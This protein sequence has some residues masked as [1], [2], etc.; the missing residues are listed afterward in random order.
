MSD[1][2]RTYI[3]FDAPS[4]PKARPKLGF[5]DISGFEP[6]VKKQ[7]T[8]NDKKINEWEELESISYFK[9][10]DLISEGP[11]EG[12]CDPAG[13]LVS[14]SGI[15]KG[16]YLDNTP[17]INENDTINYRDVSTVLMHGATGQDAI[18]TGQTGAFQ[19]MEDFSY[20]SQ[21]KSKGVVLPS[22]SSFGGEPTASFDGHHTIQDSD[23]DWVALTFNI[24]RLNAIDLN[25]DDGEI[26]PNSLKLRIEGDYTGV[27]HHTMVDDTNLGDWE[28][29]VDGKLLDPVAGTCTTDLT[30]NGIATSPYQEDILFKLVDGRDEDGKR[31]TNRRISVRN[32]T[33]LPENFS[34]VHSVKLESVTEIIKSNMSYPGSA[35]VGSVI[36]AN[37]LPRAPERTFHLKLKKVKVPS[38]YVENDDASQSRHPGTWDG[39]FKDELEWTDN[40]AWIF[41]DIA[42]NERYGLGEYVKEE[43][44]DKWQLFKIAKYC[45]EPVPTSRGNTSYK[46]GDPENEKYV[47]ERRFSCN[48]FLN[49]KME[50]Y[51]ALSEI[52]SVFKGMAFYNGSEVYVSQDSLSEPV[53]N[54]TNSNVLEGNFTYHGSSKN[55]RFTAVKVAYKD[56][57]DNFLPKYEYIEDPEGIIRH[58][59]IEKESAALGCTSRDQ[60]LRLGRW[61]LLT[62]NNEQEVVRFSTDKQGGYLRPGDVIGISDDNRTNFK[63]G[64]RVAKVVGD[65]ATSVDENHILLDQTLDIDEANFKYLKI[66]FIIPN[67]G[68]L[69]EDDEEG[70]GAEKQ[71]KTF[72]HRKGHH[73]GVIDDGYRSA[74]IPLNSQTSDNSHAGVDLH[75][76]FENTNEGTKIKTT[77]FLDML[78]ES[79][80]KN[81]EFMQGGELHPGTLND[82]FLESGVF[83]ANAGFVQH[84][85]RA[86]NNQ[87]KITEGAV[88]IVEASGD[89]R[90]QTK[91][92]RVLAVAEEDDATFT[93]AAL[94]YNRDKFKDVDS[95]STIY[96]SSTQLISVTPSHG[97]TQPNDRQGVPPPTPESEIFTPTIIGGIPDNNVSL[98]INRTGDLDQNDGTF[99]PKIEL[100]FFNDYGNEGQNVTHFDYKIQEISNVYYEK[101]KDAGSV[102]QATGLYHSLKDGSYV[103]SDK[104]GDFGEIS[105]LTGSK[106]SEFYDPTIPNFRSDFTDKVISEVG[107][108]IEKIEFSGIEKCAES[109]ST[110]SLHLYSGVKTEVGALKEETWH[111]IRWKASRK[112]TISDAS[113]EEKV[114]F[115][116]SSADITPPGEPKGFEGQLFF[117]NLYEFN[118][119]NDSAADL[120]LVRLYTGINGPALGDTPIHELQA[121][122]S[123]DQWHTFNI[124]NYPDLADSLNQ[125]FYLTSVDVAGNESL[126]N[127]DPDKRW[128]KT[129]V[130]R[131]G[132]D[133]GQLPEIV[134]TTQYDNADRQSYINIDIDPGDLNDVED[135]PNFEKYTIT[136]YE[137]GTEN[138]LNTYDITEEIVSSPEVTYN[139]R[140]GKAY[141]AKF[142][143][144]TKGGDYVFKEFDG[145]TRVGIIA[146]SDSLDPDK[147][148]NFT[149]ELRFGDTV[150]LEWNYSLNSNDI[151]HGV[152]YSGNSSFGDP[153][154]VDWEE[155]RTVDYPTAYVTQFLTPEEV[156]Y[157]EG[158]PNETLRYAIDLYDFDGNTSGPIESA[159]PIIFSDYPTSSDGFT[160]NPIQLV[161]DKWFLKAHADSIAQSVVDSS[162]FLGFQAW[163]YDKTN[164]GF[165]GIVDLDSSHEGEYP[166]IPGKQLEFL[167]IV[168]RKS[169]DIRWL[170]KTDSAVFVDTEPPTTLGDF[171]GEIWF[172]ELYRFKWNKPPEGD[173]EKIQ[174][175]T[176]ASHGNGVDPIPENL[177]IERF[178]PTSQEILF[179]T[180]EYKDLAVSESFYATAVDFSNN[181]GDI[182]SKV[183]V[184]RLGLDSSPFGD[185]KLRVG[186]FLR[187][188]ESFITGNIEPFPSA[189]ELDDNFKEYRIRLFDDSL[190]PL[191]TVY[192]T[193]ANDL[194][195]PDIEFKVT[196]GK[197][198]TVELCV[199]TEGGKYL[200]DSDLKEDIISA[201]DDTPPGS[202]GNFGGS[203]IDNKWYQ[204]NWDEPTD[205]DIEKIQLYTGV[206]VA[207]AKVFY[208]KPEPTS[209]EIVFHKNN[210]IANDLTTDS[211]FYIAA[212]DFSNNV[213][214][215][216]PAAGIQVG[217]LQGLGATDFQVGSEYNTAE[218]RP[219]ITGNIIDNSALENDDRFLQF[220]IK[221]IDK[222]NNKLLDTKLFKDG[223]AAPDL[224]YPAIAGKE[225]EL[226]LDGQTRD[227][228]YI[229]GI[230]KTITALGDLNP[231]AQI[232]NFSVT[233]PFDDLVF[234]WNPPAEPDCEQVVI[235]SGDSNPPT[236]EYKTVNKYAFFDAPIQ[237]FVEAGQAIHFGAKA[238]DLSDNESPMSNIKSFDLKANT[239]AD[240][241]FSNESIVELED[242]TNGIRKYYRTGD[243]D[244]SSKD[245]DFFETFILKIGPKDKYSVQWDEVEAP[246]GNFKYEVIP[247]VD[248]YYQ[249]WSQAKDKT[250]LSKLTYPIKEFSVSADDAGPNQVDS[251][252]LSVYGDGVFVSWKDNSARPIDFSHYN[253]YTGVGTS[254]TGPLDNLHS[255]TIHTSEY[256]YLKSSDLNNDKFA[257]EIEAKDISNNDEGR[258][259]KEVTLQNHYAAVSNLTV[260]SGILLDD[261]DGTYNSFASFIGTIPDKDDAESMVTELWR[262]NTAGNLAGSQVTEVDQTLNKSPGIFNN[263]VVGEH[264]SIR[265]KVKY[266]NGTTS[267]TWK[268]SAPSSFIA[269][270][271]VQSL[272]G[273]N[274]TNNFTAIS[275]PKQVHLSWD[276]DYTSRP[277]DLKYVNIK[278][279][280]GTSITY[281]IAPG[282]FFIDSDIEPGTV[283][284]Y[285]LELEDRSG[286]K[287]TNNKT[288]T[289]TGGQISNDYLHSLAANKIT[290]GKI[291]AG[292][293]EIS[294]D[295]AIKSSNVVNEGQGAGFFLSGTH[296][297]VGDP[298]TGG[299]GLFFTEDDDGDGTPDILEIRGNF[300]AGEVE[301]GQSSETSLKINQDGE[302]YIGDIN[303]IRIVDGTSTNIASGFF[304]HDLNAE[305]SS[306]QYK[307]KIQDHFGSN[308]QLNYL[309]DHKF[310][311]I[312]YREEGGRKYRDSIPISGH[313]VKDEVILSKAIN[314]NVND[315]NIPLNLHSY[316]IIG[317]KFLV[318]NSGTLYARDAVVAG[319]VTAN[320]F[321]A[322]EKMS[323]GTNDGNAAGTLIQSYGYTDSS[324]AH[325]DDGWRIVGDGT[326]IFKNINVKGGT[327][328]GIDY[329][330]IGPDKNFWVDDKG[331]L[332]IGTSPLFADRKFHVSKEGYITALGGALISGSVKLGDAIIGENTL[333]TINDAGIKAISPTDGTKFWNIKA[334]GSAEFK[335]IDIQGGNFSAG[336]IDI[337]SENEGFHVDSNGSFYIGDGTTTKLFEVDKDG[338]LKGKNSEFE[339]AKITSLNADSNI[340]VGADILITK[341]SIRHGD[342][343][344]LNGDGSATFGKINVTGGAITGVALDIGDPGFHVDV[345]GN[346]HI[347]T[348]TDANDFTTAPFSVDTDG[349]LIATSA[350]I[351]GTIGGDGF[352]AGQANEHVYISS[353]GIYGPSLGNQQFLIK[354]DGEAMFKNIDVQGGSI[355][356]GTLNIG[357]FRVAAN[358]SFHLGDAGAFSDDLTRF[359]V[360]NAGALKATSATITG[361]LGVGHGIRIKKT[362]SNWIDILP[363]V[364]SSK[365]NKFKL[366]GDGKAKFT[367]L[368]V[369][370]PAGSSSLSVGNTSWFN[371]SNDGAMSIGTSKTVGVDPAGGSLGS[372]TDNNFHVTTAGALTAASATIDGT[373]HAKNGSLLG[374]NASKGWAVTN[375][376][377]QGITPAVATLN[378]NGGFKLQSISGDAGGLTTN[379]ITSSDGTA[380][381]LALDGTTSSIPN[382]STS[383]TSAGNIAKQVSTQFCGEI[384]YPVDGQEYTLISNNRIEYKITEVDLAFSGPPGSVDPTVSIDFIGDGITWVDTST[385]IEGTPAT[386]K[387]LGTINNSNHMRIK[388]DDAKGK[389]SIQFNIKLQRN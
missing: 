80:N 212:V 249:G 2:H 134:L 295:G 58:G 385:I 27:L 205:T 153:L 356:G 379:S 195:T 162:E 100:Y 254:F 68:K 101:L 129:N 148:E 296:F 46:P 132:T 285:E 316:E 82:Y 348:K 333:F 86:N 118:W 300:T 97:D 199:H 352:R 36:R 243:M 389:T 69:S 115:F 313:L 250:K 20:V 337:G 221:I 189:I 343:W 375:S 83:Q 64:G 175:Y 303:P 373:L 49:N 143:L 28:N 241:E 33:S 142:G 113:S 255:S 349:N 73:I 252:N 332:G 309:S 342:D 39:T 331:E 329:I 43:N 232:T 40:P 338:N 207:N 181:T 218:F 125:D 3:T 166:A 179:G 18:Y 128:A 193:E 102:E 62:S 317:V 75:N 222:D 93:I 327:I 85:D 103:K 70:V 116:R 233:K 16:I 169:G 259:F 388:T 323:L 251:V 48:L 1:E 377:I 202:I 367:N 236:K 225:Y 284:E 23:V 335:D 288:T 308:P 34:R 8:T 282:T 192:I 84:Q 311:N 21:T 387:I 67:S 52:A 339:G 370:G 44:I 184:S 165:M 256:I 61:I 147:V 358:G 9:A 248:Y 55:T 42:T 194:T 245:S 99:N 120:D 121:E 19:W 263:L 183:S 170:T 334:D 30:I 261:G 267:N 188:N 374:Q 211:K 144:V 87:Q 350:T 14:G 123:A 124:A 365:D 119:K 376:T 244:H 90:Q 111:E 187:G 364:I 38:I 72:I 79:P 59:L 47:Q 275:G 112:H 266:K 315:N 294:D 292:E 359:S 174:L 177:F 229:G 237:E 270:G 286:N 274:L 78:Q 239:N 178:E 301:I 12:F 265:A 155:V 151:S 156:E 346:V 247:G 325:Y 29:Q 5:R 386:H 272:D 310:L 312:Q 197:S 380:F 117:N 307:V 264:Y 168:K 230:N 131:I 326:A 206:S 381:S 269:P 180:E 219:Y 324:S 157:I 26:I 361:E 360:S 354:P 114:A 159:N 35:Q 268:S 372:H 210:P 91:E 336:T 110:P 224:S 109:N 279:T 220:R 304:P 240:V 137:S 37:Y 217:S 253:L 196:P 203:L 215:P 32:L 108:G 226:I 98:S 74:L 106:G 378:G 287:S 81:D 209:Q 302:I 238:I 17:I 235:Y 154:P 297:R 362:N 10:L 182:S 7:D 171:T 321:E 293:I 382:F 167:L 54:F 25:S 306:D 291:G 50:A 273:T 200:C 344:I 161:A 31:R 371:V 89:A 214:T 146:A 355:N 258:K 366:E 368:T 126:E 341:A 227:F 130:S 107:V 24:G 56:K 347:G 186:T 136:I 330:Q 53:L 298:S 328:D 105:F 104:C 353:V 246:L 88:Y 4:Q 96:K 138:I 340:S 51:K 163:V 150:V 204:F 384:L 228:G 299:D 45:D 60:A 223:S 351:E 242:P 149:S 318:T 139:A 65:N 94:E 280:G 127:V 63:S 208:E 305:Y 76:Y 173:I 383:S 158:L 164:G 95:L 145:K 92:F 216:G 160:T 213:G 320:S 191:D 22:A 6:L 71:F 152:L 262:P 319:T 322:D 231:P 57:D 281:Q 276:Y 277:K 234:S 190:S 11:I 357:Q 201:K 172:N 345:N 289:V 140:G 77:M 314:V 290:A 369:D 260:T 176:G 41:Y 278:R 133:P 271:Y 15:L 257:V 141:E 283:Y 198:Y 135:D 185:L 122:S 363:G 66:S 13:N